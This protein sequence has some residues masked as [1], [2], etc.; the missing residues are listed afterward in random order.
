[1]NTTYEDW[2]AHFESKLDKIPDER[3]RKPG[4]FLSVVPCGAEW[5]SYLEF[6]RR[7]W[8]FGRITEFPFC[9]LTLYAGVAFHDYES[10]DFWQP[11]A[12]AVGVNSIS[13]KQYNQ[14]TDYF[15]YHAKEIGLE[16]LESSRGKDFVGTPI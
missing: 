13:Q 16:T 5:E 12:K 11:F 3:S 8:C 1:M 9:L 14:L 10:G 6:V 4:A 2:D 15:F 7:K